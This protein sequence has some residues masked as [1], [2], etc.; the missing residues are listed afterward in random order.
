V[1]RRKSVRS[2]ESLRG[3]RRARWSGH[4]L[5]DEMARFDA[6]AFTR[7]MSPRLKAERRKMVLR[8]FQDGFAA[9]HMTP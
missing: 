5:I 8:C 1:E 6:R 9:A 4:P 3:N 2:S 7:L